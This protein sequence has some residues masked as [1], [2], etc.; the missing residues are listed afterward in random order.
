MA[1]NDVVIR[2]SAIDRASAVFARIEN[3]FSQRMQRITQQTQKF[4]Q[5]ME[6]V[7]NMKIAADGVR[8]FS[9]SITSALAKPIDAGMSFEAAMSKV[10]SVSLVGY[11]DE[12]GKKTA[13]YDK[14]LRALTDTAQ[15]F[16]A[17]TAWSASQI[18][19]GQGFLGMAGFK[20]DQI[21]AATGGMLS[22]AS[23]MGSELGE[24]ADILSNIGT[25]MFGQDATNQFNR[26]AD[27]MAHV[28]STS[29]SDIQ[30]LGYAM[31][32]VAPVAAT[33]RVS[34]EQLAGAMAMTHNSG[35]QASQAGTSLRGILSRLSAP[36]ETVG[37]RL[38]AIGVKTQD[39]KGNLRDFPTIL[40]D[41]YEGTKKLGTAQRIE[42]F[43]DIAGLEASSAMAVL[44]KSAG[45]GELQ[46]Y[47]SDMGDKGENV[48]G[49]AAQIAK[50]RIDNLKGRI[51]ILGS[52][53]EALYIN[54]FNR[55]KPILKTAVEWIT[56]LV[57]KINDWISAHPGLTSALFKAVAILGG[58]TAAIATAISG[59]AAFTAVLAGVKLGLVAISTFSGPLL[60]IGGIALI[61]YK[62][63]EPLSAFFGNLFEG[64]KAGLAPVTHAFSILKNALAPLTIVFVSLF[65]PIAEAS[66]AVLSF[67]DVGS[68]VGM[69]IGQTLGFAITAI[70]LG[71][72]KTIN[73]LKSLGTWLGETFAKF[74]QMTEGLNFVDQIKFAFQQVNNFIT[75]FD[76]NASGTAII[77]TL[78]EGVVFAGKQLWQAVYN[79]FLYVRQLLP[80]SNA[81]EGP[82]SN[83]YES[84]Q[85]IIMT[86]AGGVASVG[87]YLWETVFQIFQVSKQ[88]VLNAFSDLGNWITD[89]FSDPLKNTLFLAM[90]IAIIDSIILALGN[91]VNFVKPYFVGFT[92]KVTSYFGFDAQVV[93]SYYH[94]LISSFSFS[95]LYQVYENIKEVVS[96]IGGKLIKFGSFININGIA[97]ASISVFQT[98]LQ[99]LPGV[100]K[101]LIV[102]GSS[103]ASAI[104][105]IFSFGSNLTGLSSSI[106]NFLGGFSHFSSI[107]IGFVGTFASKLY[108]LTS[109]LPTPVKL[110]FLF[111][112]AIAL[113][114]SNFSTIAPM[115]GEFGIM[116][117]DILENL[118]GFQQTLLKFVG[119]ET[120]NIGLVLTGFSGIAI[121]YS[122]VRAVYTFKDELFS[123][124]SFINEWWQSLGTTAKW[125]SGI[126]IAVS[127]LIPLFAVLG[128]LLVSPFALLV[129]ALTTGVTVVTTFKS[130]IL[131]VANE[132]YTFV[133]G[134]T[135]KIGNIF[136]S[137]FGEGTWMSF[138]SV[139]KD[140][141][142]V[143]ALSAFAFF[144]AFVGKKFFQTFSAIRKA[145]QCEKNP[146]LAC[147]LPDRKELVKRIKQGQYGLALSNMGGNCGL[148][149]NQ[150]ANNTA[151]A[152]GR[153]ANRTNGQLALFHE[154]SQNATQ[155]TTTT[156]RQRFGNMFTWMGNQ[157]R[158]TASLATRAYS[159]IG[160]AISRS[161]NSTQGAFRDASRHY[162][163]FMD[164]ARLAGTAIGERN[165]QNNLVRGGLRGPNFNN[166]DRQV[167]GGR[168][169][170]RI[171]DE[172]YRHEE[173]RLRIGG[174]RDGISTPRMERESSIA[175]SQSQSIGMREANRLA[176]IERTHLQQLAVTTDN[177]LQSINRSVRTHYANIP[178]F[179]NTAYTSMRERTN[180]FATNTTGRFRTMRDRIRGVFSGIGSQRANPNI[181]QPEQPRSNMGKTA[182][183]A[184]IVA[185]IAGLAMFSSVD[186]QASELNSTLS[187]TSQKLEETQASLSLLDKAGNVLGATW[188]W[189]TNNPFEALMIGMTLMELLPVLGSLGTAFT[190]LGTTMMTSV[191]AL[192]SL[193]TVAAGAAAAFAGWQLG[194]WLYNEFTVVQETAIS[195][196][197]WFVETG[198]SI[199][200]AILEGWNITV[201]IATSI[202]A[203]FEYLFSLSWLEAGANL[204]GSFIE[205]FKSHSILELITMGFQAISDY[206]YSISWVDAAIRIVS[207][208]IEGIAS[209][210]ILGSV[211]PIFNAASNWLSQQSWF[212]EGANMVKS[213]AAGAKSAH[214]SVV[215]AV[216][217]LF[218]DTGKKYL[219]H[220]DAKMGPLAEISTTGRNFVK[221]WA[222]GVLSEK[223]TA[224]QGTSKMLAG[225]A[226]TLIGTSMPAMALPDINTE[227]LGQQISSGFTQS[228]DG[229][230]NQAIQAPSVLMKGVFDG[231]VNGAL[232]G[233]T[234]GFKDTLSNAPNQILGGLGNLGVDV[235][236][237]MP[238]M[239]NFGLPEGLSLP[240]ASGGLE[241][242][243]LPG[244]DSLTNG[245]NPAEANPLSDSQPVQQ[246]ALQ[247]SPAPQQPNQQGS[248]GTTITFGDII[249][250]IK[251]SLSGDA[252]DIANS[253][254][255]LAVDRIEE[256]IRESRFDS[257]YDMDS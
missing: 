240:S 164:N 20:P 198:A 147:M 145:K 90:K 36:T 146:L 216:V 111:G 124:V 141:L 48:A 248:A 23:A 34:L 117:K 165:P 128:T 228:I 196:V 118:T 47:I 138:S 189:V 190:T 28:T 69:S 64:I 92:Q 144:A 170:N 187:T 185:G 100:G 61:V 143:G 106:F 242:P 153:L 256:K 59:A 221:T 89:F 19:Q 53:M 254:A 104:G 121:I 210:D 220:S 15:E 131:S 207:T 166:N 159:G 29:N 233:I 199:K 109:F 72:T 38:E 22:A 81:K 174:I 91:A 214:Q 110:L 40:K 107:V 223:A 57:R 87:S 167:Y 58:L 63:W 149:S 45:A 31:K 211:T 37:T 179:A 26:M 129:V 155:R 232:G 25:A 114:T 17:K 16:G 177:T 250:N 136:D 125:I 8:S 67:G 151:N 158:N 182:A 55:V 68:S 93:K 193:T 52:V 201:E 39:A 230:K 62:Y 140:F 33:A 97:N 6:R 115:L 245:F 195:I 152:V 13:E 103:F 96:A 234:Q 77:N 222:G 119:S 80:F 168:V 197:G 54:V 247:P 122:L 227:Q 135:E 9:N 186:A 224:S 176:R 139:I 18:A 251:G 7:A 213:W 225:V 78:V 21:K 116:L 99:Y 2:V 5:T 194:T 123:F 44:V 157:W 70:A 173:R 66:Q 257:L 178:T 236:S 49:R 205:G 215:T 11:L 3:N 56:Q 209:V 126:T 127:G 156:M 95:S 98:I 134:V 175:H 76:F 24:T 65:S 188:N 94:S 150:C 163:N 202:G 84:G 46:K 86:I 74:A 249:I 108:A 161:I 132:I 192:G 75:T 181:E 82:F 79:V 160:P 35:I 171:G 4:Q 231:D 12:N 203:G 112:G 183:I 60:A 30:M 191:T 142:M 27:V 71:I 226:S 73:L 41:I 255:E 88:T 1:M 219:N 105:I 120:I 218:S 51:T 10:A 14:Q 42:A 246:K 208:W 154:N 200:N 243:G 85:R 241:M 217:D 133:S 235:S 101:A 206:F 238:D 83:L 130:E 148:I 229:F 184:G 244:L 169:S 204:I 50:I 252:E 239:S 237:N 212:Q 43:A 137:V 102:V 32:Y 172:R 180:Q 162:S 253:V 113:F